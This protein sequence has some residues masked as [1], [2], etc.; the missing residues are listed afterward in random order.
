MSDK[1]PVV[2]DIETYRN[3]FLV[4]FRSCGNGVTKTFEAFE[5]QELDVAGLAKILR[6]ITIVTFNGTGY[7]MPMVALAL[8]GVSCSALKDA[9]D[10][11][12]EQR[13]KPWDFERKYGV[14]IL[15]EWDTVDVMDV[16]PGQGSLKIYGGRL[17]C[18]RMQDLPIEPSQLISP[19]EREQLKAYCLND[20]QTTI[21]LWS[22]LK[23]QLDLREAMSVE[24]DR[25]LRSKS[26]AQIAEAVIRDK[27][28]ALVGWKVSRPDIPKDTTFQ[29]KAP[30][31][32]YF[33]PGSPLRDLLRD[34]ESTHFTLSD[35]G[36]VLMPKF[37]ETQSI[38]IGLGVYRM[39]IG[40]LHSSEESVSHRT[41]ETYF[42]EDRDVT[43]YYPS[44]ILSQGLYPSHLG[45]KFLDV[46]RDIVEKR[47][48][49]KRSGNT[50]AA[51]ALKIVINASFGKFGSHWSAL[52]SPSLLIQTTI[53][54]Q[55]CL[56]M[57]IEELKDQGIPVVSANTDGIVIKCPRDREAEMRAVI[58]D[59]EL[60]TGLNTEGTPYSALYSKDVNNYLAFKPGGGHK[61]KGQY[62]A[63]GLQKNPSNAICVDAVVAYI[64]HGTRISD[65]V[66]N[67]K[68]VRKFV[69]IKKVT[70]GGTYEYGDG[71]TEFLGKAV[72]WFYASGSTGLIRYKPKT[73]TKDGVETTQ[74]VGNTVGRSEGCSPLMELPEYHLV[75]VDL[76]HGWYIDESYRILS[77]IGF[78]HAPVSEE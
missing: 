22:H 74:E 42:L 1:K 49:A 28:S 18:Q 2:M 72:R 59:W 32:V 78:K 14:R 16:A 67:C 24:Y 4:A 13:L 8:T 56:L 36:K 37:L 41:D 21:D 68:D 25:D 5:G 73:T 52:Y 64:E 10:S 17:H 70:G 69:T 15:R 35:S 43:S 75:P 23:P 57:L 27:V 55:L 6:N 7:D 48:E 46:Y 62:A 12:I 58:A 61:A 71:S 20:L 51:E 33:R 40:G 34:I 50:V 39:G 26:D 54:G 29:Y 63:A 19:E 53:T 47:I 65:T 11:I 60:F 9:S 76:D 30:P 45:D 77:D 44:L 3:Y 38:Q 66:H 31:I